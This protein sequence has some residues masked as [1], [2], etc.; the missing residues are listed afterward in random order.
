[1]AGSL[2]V[3]DKQSDRFLGQCGL[4]CLEG[5]ADYPDI[6]LAFVINKAFWGMG[7]AAEAAREVVKFGFSLDRWQKIAAVTMRENVPAQRVLKKLGFTYVDEKYLYGRRVMY[8]EL[9]KISFLNLQ[10]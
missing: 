5:K 1:M 10:I 8:Y 4:Q 9:T 3:R 6:E 2:A 7:Y